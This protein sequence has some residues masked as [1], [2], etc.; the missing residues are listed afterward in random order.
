M[1]WISFMILFSILQ[2]RFYEIHTR[3]WVDRAVPFW[4]FLCLTLLITEWI[5]RIFLELDLE[6]WLGVAL[7]FGVFLFG[8]FINLIFQKEG[9]GIAKKWQTLPSFFSF[10]AVFISLLWV[11]GSQST[12]ALEDAYAQILML[13]VSSVCLTVILVPISD[14]LLLSDI[15]KAWE[16]FP[17]MLISGLILMSIFLGIV[18]NF[19]P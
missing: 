14:R 7:S 16:G 2:I 11:Y 1:S 19:L 10:S 13:S 12:F 18:K 15:P 8:E 17:I 3:E 9:K 4:A 6:W 5:R